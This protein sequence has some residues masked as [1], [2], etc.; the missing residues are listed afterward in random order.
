MSA[1][2]PHTS[3]SDV[4]SAK[5]SSSK[6][7]EALAHVS[8]RQWQNLLVEFTDSLGPPDRNSE[9]V[10]RELTDACAALC[11]HLAQSD[12]HGCV[13][14]D[15]DLLTLT[16]VRLGHAPD[17]YAERPT[18]LVPTR[19]QLP[20]PPGGRADLNKLIASKSA[21]LMAEAVFAHGPPRTPQHVVWPIQH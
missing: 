4:T 11:G 13:S 12:I 2:Y 16:F 17:P 15:L 5:P 14:A 9:Q 6:V 1:G 21:E 8:H 18:Y 20:I 3:Y 19:A 10:S 7:F